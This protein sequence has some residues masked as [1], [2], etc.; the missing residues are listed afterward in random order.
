[1]AQQ[2]AEIDPWPPAVIA[3]GYL[4]RFEISSD[5]GIQVDPLS[6]HNRITAS[7]KTALLIEPV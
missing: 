5:V 2:L 6:W 1:M 3:C 7:A 4:P